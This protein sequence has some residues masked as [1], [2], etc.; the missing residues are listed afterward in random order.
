MQKSVDKLKVLLYDTY[1]NNL[2]RFKVIVPTKEVM[3]H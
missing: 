3:Q 1:I 2:H